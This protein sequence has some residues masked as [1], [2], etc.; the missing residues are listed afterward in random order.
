MLR[1]LTPRWLLVATLA[2]FGAG[3]LAAV[4]MYQAMGA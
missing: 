1:D 4:W 3:I 2:A